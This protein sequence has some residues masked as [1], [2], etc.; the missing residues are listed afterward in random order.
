MK[1]ALIYLTL[2][3]YS[4]AL[5]RPAAPVF[6]DL[7][8]HAFWKMEHMATVHFEN[9]QYHVHAELLEASQKEPGKY[10]AGSSASLKTGKPLFVHLCSKTV[11]SLF[12]VIRVSETGSVPTGEPEAVILTIT[13]PPPQASA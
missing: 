10:P 12:K 8:A 1:K 4:F 13:T 9:G 11:Y 6:T 7:L 2:F 5:F 3:L